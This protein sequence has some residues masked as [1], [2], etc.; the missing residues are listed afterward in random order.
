MK[1]YP[2]YEGFMGYING[3]YMLFATESEYAEYYLAHET[4]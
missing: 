3:E 4:N 1:G 2:T